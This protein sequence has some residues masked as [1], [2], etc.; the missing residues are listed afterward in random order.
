[1]LFAK[2]PIVDDLAPFSHS[3]ARCPL[4][5]ALLNSARR[6]LYTDDPSYCD[7]L[8][9]LA[10]AAA[11]FNDRSHHYRSAELAL[12]CARLDTAIHLTAVGVRFR[13]ILLRE[14]AVEVIESLLQEPY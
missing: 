2:S 6:W 8:S 7:K 13:A 1:M 4:Y 14:E 10:T 11:R 5:R 3:H 12:A 9:R